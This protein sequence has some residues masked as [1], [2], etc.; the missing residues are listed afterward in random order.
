MVRCSEAEAQVIN[1][2]SAEHLLISPLSF[3]VVIPCL[4]RLPQLRR[5]IIRERRGVITSTTS[6]A[7]LAGYIY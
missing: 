6:R 7:R 4:D 1:R 2:Y 5:I 3:I